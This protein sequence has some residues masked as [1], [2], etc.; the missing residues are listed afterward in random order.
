MSLND[1]DVPLTAAERRSLLD[2]LTAE[3]QATAAS[4]SVAELE[5]LLNRLVVGTQWS[6]PTIGA[7][8][9]LFRV[10]KMDR[11][12][13]NVAEAGA[14]PGGAASAGRVN[15]PGCSVLYLADSPA[16]AISEVRSGEG[17]YCL[18]EWRVTENRVALANGGIVEDDLVAVFGTGDK[19]AADVGGYVDDEVRQLFTTIFRLAPSDNAALYRWSIAAARAVGFSHRCG[20]TARSYQDGRTKFEGRHPFAGVAYVSVRSDQ[21]RVNFAFNDLGQAYVELTNVQWVEHRGDGE[22]SGLDF[23]SS[24]NADGTIQWLGRPAKLVI[25]PGG[26]ANVTKVGANVWKFET[27]DGEVPGFS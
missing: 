17:T 23:A 1:E 27:I 26:G 19:A 16:T 4:R 24:W 2:A 8:A 20:R 5:H 14:P 6:L 7:G 9:R 25:P 21:R 11:K 3:V 15:E 18:T 22:T 13:I 10:R 12:A